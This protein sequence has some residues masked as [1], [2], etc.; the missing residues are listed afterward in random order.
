MELFYTTKML[1]FSVQSGLFPHWQETILWIFCGFSR[2]KWVPTA[3]AR[4]VLSGYGSIQRWGGL[5]KWFSWMVRW[6][7]EQYRSTPLTPLH[8]TALG[9]AIPNQA[10]TYSKA[11][12][13]SKRPP[14]WS[15]FEF[16][17][18]SGKCFNVKESRIQKKKRVRPLTLS[19]AC[20]ESSDCC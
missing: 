6:R 19:W 10:C 13:Q 18:T 7:W 12:R 1:F 5:L 9:P 14:W 15:N 20:C 8:A 3:S 16:K 11:P 2:C 4:G 17:R